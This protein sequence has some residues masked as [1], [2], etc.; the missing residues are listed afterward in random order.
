MRA[1]EDRILNSYGWVDAQRGIVRIP[2]AQAMAM[3]VA[4]G[5]PARTGATPYAPQGLPE[6]SDSGRTL[7]PSG[8]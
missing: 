5:L 6:T 3:T 7:P 1:E 8:R 2:I 4:Q